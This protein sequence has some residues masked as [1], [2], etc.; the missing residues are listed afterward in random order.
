MIKT[1]INI[2]RLGRPHGLHGWMLVN[3]FAD[4]AEQVFNYAPLYIQDGKAW[5]ELDITAH[6]TQSKKLMIHLKGCDTPEAAKAYTNKFLVIDRSQLPEPDTDEYYWS[7]LEGLRVINQAG[8]E[9]GHVDH[10]INTG[11]ND[12]FVVKGKK[13]HLIPHLK[14]F[15]L[16]IDLKEKKIIVDWEEDF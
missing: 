15:T 3:S 11:A 7:D 1:P 12:I 16:S 14:E 10:L 9:L 5:R 6:K 4:P 2:A 13:Q 8:V